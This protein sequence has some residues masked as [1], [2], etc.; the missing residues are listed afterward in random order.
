MVS[1]HALLLT[2]LDLAVEIHLLRA[3]FPHNSAACC[4]D[5]ADG[6]NETGRNVAMFEDGSDSI[7][8]ARVEFIGA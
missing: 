8:L 2:R 5:D 7:G 1:S 6:Y 4:E 3:S